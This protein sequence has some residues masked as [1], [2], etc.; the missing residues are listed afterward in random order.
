MSRGRVTTNDTEKL[1]DAEQRLVFLEQE[2]KSMKDR[3]VELRKAGASMTRVVKSNTLPQVIEKKEVDPRLAE[4]EALV[5]QLRLEKELLQE[6]M[7]TKLD[8]LK[9][10]LSDKTETAVAYS[11]DINRLT[12]EL[13]KLKEQIKGLVPASAPPRQ[14][15]GELARLRAL[16][17]ELGAKLDDAV[18]VRDKTIEMGR[19]AEMTTLMFMQQNADIEG[20]VALMIQQQK[21]LL[22]TLE[23]NGLIRLVD[24]TQLTLS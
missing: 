21:V 19:K 10:Q 18:R 11:N 7:V 20:K 8:D 12:A 22:A 2:N 5:K 4:L 9:G 14:D 23:E 17:A 13:S 16:V 6:K 24:Q 3:L 1:R 15:D